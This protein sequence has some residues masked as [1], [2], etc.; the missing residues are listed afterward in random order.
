[1]GSRIIDVIKSDHRDIESYYNR[2]IRTSDHSEQKK[3]QNQF[4]WELARHAVG[5]ELVVYPAFEKLVPSGVEMAN[6][7][8]REHQTV[9]RIQS[10][11]KAVQNL[12]V[13]I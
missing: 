2:I 12:T 1:M 13:F 4:T 6:K 8:R 5:E 3:F 7:D 10:E 9:S 11:L